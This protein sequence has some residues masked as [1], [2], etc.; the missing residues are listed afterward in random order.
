[1]ITFTILGGLALSGL[2]AGF[3]FQRSR[4]CF[5]SALRDLFLFGAT[6]MTRAILILLLVIAGGGVLL[7]Q[8]EAPVLWGQTPVILTLGGALFGV[9]MV[10]AGSCVAGAFWRLGE[11][12]AS[13]L[14]ILGGVLVGTWTYV[15][16]PGNPELGPM[17]S[18]PAWAPVAGLALLLGALRWWERRQQPLGEEL[19]PE[20]PGHSWRAPWPAEAG[21]VVMALMLLLYA[22]V[23]GETWTVTRAFLL[24][25]SA[26]IFSLGLV[27]G[28]WLGGQLGREWRFRG[29]GSW[30][31]AG[32][33]LAGGL[34]MGYGARLGWGCTIGAV[35]GGL[36]NVSVQ[37]FFWLAGAVVGSSIGAN[38]LRRF[39]FRY[40]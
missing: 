24:E 21:A 38:L 1:M 27:G 28:G 40:L 29:A 4:L 5:A 17:G 20:R 9:G 8:G 33:R 30:P 23:A 25:P 10:L 37:P 32:L 31:E 34:M 35:M 11:G 26:M 7:H 36:A 22:T 14:W 12:Q 2:L 39:F 19:P 6:E 15:Y 18:P 13:Q 3:I 16:T